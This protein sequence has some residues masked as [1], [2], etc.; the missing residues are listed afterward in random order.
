MSNGMSRRSWFGGFAAAALAPLAGKLAIARGWRRA[1]ERPE[2]AATANSDRQGLTTV[3]TYDSDG[4][5]IGVI[6]PVGVE[7]MSYTYH[8]P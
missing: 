8:S 5:L 1:G 2:A 4:R 6:E 3:Y 7:V